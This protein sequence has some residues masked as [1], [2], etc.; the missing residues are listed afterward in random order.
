MYYNAMGDRVRTRK[1]LPRGFPSFL[2][3]EVM[4]ENKMAK[5]CNNCGTENQK[6]NVPYVVHESAMARSERHNKRLWIVI[7]V[8][9]GALIGTNL[10][11]IIYENS[12][13]DYI[14]TE[15]YDVEQDADGG[16]NNSIINGGEI[17][18][19]EAEN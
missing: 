4:E 1:P 5:T 17:V 10:A 13:E 9:I 3:Y 11:W 8:L 16:D 18:N 19:G 12:F 14:I 2:I 6:V 7:L 15:E